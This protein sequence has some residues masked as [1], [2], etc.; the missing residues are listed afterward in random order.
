MK[1]VDL[2]KGVLRKQCQNRKGQTFVGNAETDESAWPARV[3]DSV[4]TA[5]RDWRRKQQEVAVQRCDSPSEDAYAL[6]QLYST[7]ATTSSYHMNS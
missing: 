6:H 3:G 2:A 4:V 7:D 1:G 5:V